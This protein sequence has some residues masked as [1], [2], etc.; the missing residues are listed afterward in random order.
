MSSP[1]EQP[2]CLRIGQRIALRGSRR[3]GTVRFFGP[4][5][6]TAAGVCPWAGIDWDDSAGKHDG[7]R[8]GVRYFDCVEGPTAGSFVRPA[9]LSAGV[10]AH[11]ALLSRYT[12]EAGP[13][14]YGSGFGKRIEAV[15]LESVAKR[16]GQLVTLRIISLAHEEVHGV[17]SDE[18]AE[19]LRRDAASVHTA[20]LSFSLISSWAGLAAVAGALPNLRCLVARYVA[21]SLG[22]LTSQRQ[23]LRYRH[24]RRA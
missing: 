24:A 8:A 16:V 10:S 12:A 6:G 20:D 17:G 4:V 1:S 13:S 15:G 3:V 18:D 14:S 21:L 23:P 2:D 11:Q 22:A 5:E 19:R 7:S 9:L